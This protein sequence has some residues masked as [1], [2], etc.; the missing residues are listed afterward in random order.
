MEWF[1]DYAN[2]KRLGK[3]LVVEGFTGAELQAYYE[4]PWCWTDSW[5]DM[6]KEQAMDTPLAREQADM[7]AIEQE[8]A[9]R[10]WTAQQILDR[11]G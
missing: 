10:N 8:Q 4:E 5:E 7:G 2:V 11:E 1:K 9:R 3:W 6:Q